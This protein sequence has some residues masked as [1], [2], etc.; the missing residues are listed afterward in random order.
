MHYQAQAV[1]RIHPIENASREA[2]ETESLCLA[3]ADSAPPWKRALDLILIVFTLPTWLTVMICL[4]LWIKITSPGPVFF[5]QERVGFQRRRFM[6]LKFRSMKVNAET[7]NHENYFDHLVQANCRMTKLDAVG[8]SRMIP[9]GRLLRASGLDE[10]PQLFNV[11]V[12]DMSLVGPRPCTSPE[13]KNYR[14]PQYERFA[15]PPGLTGHWQVN[16][17]NNTTFSDMVELDI[18]YSRNMSLALDLVIIAKTVPTLLN[19]LLEARRRGRNRAE[20]KTTA[21]A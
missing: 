20:L 2:A 15:A 16:G 9:G 1:D 8:D 21:A 5:K 14:E 12:G 7:A 18:F 10:L 11:I 3:P 4:A 6:M 13:L 17:K 19:Q